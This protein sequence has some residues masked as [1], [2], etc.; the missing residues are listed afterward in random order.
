MKSMKKRYM[1]IMAV[2]VIVAVVLGVAAWSMYI[3]GLNAVKHDANR[4]AVIEDVNGDR[5]AVETTNEQ[6]WAEL[7]QLNQNG[8]RMWIGGVVE[9][10]S[11]KW[12]FR[13]KLDSIVIAEVTIEALQA[14]IR[15]I[16]ENIDY[17]LN[18]GRAYVSARVVEI[19]S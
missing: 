15:Y 16:T 10:Y 18:I 12:G 17:W 7:I 3:D 19:H 8:T 13:F 4:W 1:G 5:L 14:T 9:R 6:V 11:N 2:P